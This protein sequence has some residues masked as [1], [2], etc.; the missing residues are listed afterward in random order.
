M[1]QIPVITKNLLIVNILAF[2][3]YLVL[4][5]YGVDLNNLLGLHYFQ[6][7][8]FHLYQL[9]TYMFMHGGFAHL[10]FN[11]FALWMFGGVIENTFGRNR[12]LIYYFVCGLGAALCQMLSQ[13]CMVYA[14]VADMGG[15]LI[16]VLSINIPY[17]TTTVGASGAIYGILLAFGMMYP[18]ERMFIFPL[19]VPIKAKWFVM[20]YV[21]IELVQ[22]LSMPGDGVAHVA[23]IGGMLFGWLLIKHWRKTS[24]SFNGWDGY[25][26]KE[27]KS[28][29][30]LGR[31]R[32]WLH[33]DRT[34]NADL[35][36]GR[37]NKASKN[38]QDWDYNARKREEE[39][40][41]DRIL[42]K[43]RRSGY[44]S[45]TDEEKRKLFERK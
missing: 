28:L 22:A 11:M 19:P 8:D 40:E 35:N 43:I 30:I 6:A 14:N 32:K 4:S 42:E 26:I 29:S 16:D 34:D 31:I 37:K 25:E 12:F 39:K 3:A 18:E 24:S 45:L 7:Q 15:T 36:F 20:G 23:H 17:S 44:A 41:M 27:K 2:M 21:V 10:F 5:G 13:F 9:V 38:Q 1:R 33:L